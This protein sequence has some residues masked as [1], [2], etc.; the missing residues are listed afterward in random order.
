MISHNNTNWE[1][2]SIT[3]Y[4]QNVTLT[5]GMHALCTC[6]YTSYRT[7]FNHSW[8]EVSKS[9]LNL[10]QRLKCE[11]PSLG[12]VPTQF[13]QCRK[14][15]DATTG[16]FVA[17]RFSSASKRQ[18][19]CTDRGGSRKLK[20][21]LLLWVWKQLQPLHVNQQTDFHVTVSKLFS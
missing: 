3:S 6:C 7:I 16:L 21:S 14:Q 1:M 15:D 9:V 10:A 11:E 17:T 8:A 18:P 2:L 5:P 20:P 13:V 12:P 4:C 19:T